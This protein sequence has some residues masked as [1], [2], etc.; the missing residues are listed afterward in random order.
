[1]KRVDRR[2]LLGLAEYE[3]V[4]EQFRKRIIADK[5]DRRFA[6]CD[7][8]SIVFENYDT[9]LFQ[10]QEMLRTERITKESAIQH[11]IETYNELIPEGAE[12]SGTMFVE[13][14]EAKVRDRR[15]AELAGLEGCI[16]LEIEGETVRA[17]NE[18][19]GVLP[20]R[21]TAVH[22]LK[23]PLGEKLADKVRKLARVVLVVDHPK[24]RVRTEIPPSVVRS[25]AEDLAA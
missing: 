3:Q 25:L 18:T 1:M 6:P 7:E 15:L 2:D 24:L 16:G 20:D 9:V 5:R 10:I 23:F 12:L 4:R 17:R 19:R 21:T 22:Y 8:L 14:P 11:E 13:I